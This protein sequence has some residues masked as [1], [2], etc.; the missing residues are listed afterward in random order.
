MYPAYLWHKL[1]LHSSKVILT[2]AIFACLANSITSQAQDRSVLN[3][4]FFDSQKI[5]YGF[6]L[7]V[8]ISNFKMK[9][10]SAYASTELDTLHS[11]VAKGAAGFKLGF[12]V[13][14]HFNDV[15]DARFSPTVSFN[16]LKLDYRYTDGSTIESLSD[17]TFVELPLLLK[18]KSVRRKNTRMYGLV[19]VNPSFKVSGT[20]EKEDNTERLLL[21]NFNLNLEF[22]AGFDLYQSLFKFSPE[23]RYSWGLLDLLDRS[24]P[25]LYSFPIQRLALHTITFYIT[26]EGGPSELKVGGGKKR[27]R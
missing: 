25:N 10:D 12:I 20:K 23:V 6:L 27:R 15:L 8:G 17:P 5:H 26:F 7:G 22:G 16:Q 1:N 19:G 13:D 4:P 9:Y 14:Y 18:Y 2:L 24:E 11:I 21:N 3:L